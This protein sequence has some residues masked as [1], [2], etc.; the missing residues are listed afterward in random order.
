[1]AG[2]LKKA[3]IMNLQFLTSFFI[4][5]M[6]VCDE[7]QFFIKNTLKFQIQ[8]SFFVRTMLTHE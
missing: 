2:K 1:M 6:C 7:G 8:T 3:G 4:R 5:T